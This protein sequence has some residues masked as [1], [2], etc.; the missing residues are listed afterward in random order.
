MEEQLNETVKNTNTNITGSSTP[1]QQQKVKQRQKREI[2]VDLNDDVKVIK[3]IFSGSNSSL[4]H[5]F[6][7]EKEKEVSCITLIKGQIGLIPITDKTTNFDDD[8]VRTIKIKSDFALYCNVI[9]I[10]DGFIYIEP[11][12]SKYKVKDKT[13]IGE[14]I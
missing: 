4:T 3:K 2:I 5:D 6:H 9:T 12:F 7:I 8:N 1:A 10:K 14:F 11:R 13:V